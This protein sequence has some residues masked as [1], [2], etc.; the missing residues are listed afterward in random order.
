ME[1]RRLSHVLLFQQCLGVFAGGVG[2][3]AEH[4][5]EFGDAVFL[6]Q[7]LDF[8]NGAAVFDLLGHDVV[9]AGGRGHLGQVRDTQ[10]LVTAA[11]LAHARTHLHGDLA[12]DVGVDFVEDEQ[13]D[14]IVFRQDALHREH[15]AGNLAARRD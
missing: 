3:A 15:Y 5:G 1:F 8:G 11:Q 7:Q 13:G 9:R 2:L 6:P 10:H 12:A 4:A 14:R